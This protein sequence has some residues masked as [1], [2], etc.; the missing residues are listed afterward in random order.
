MRKTSRF[1]IPLQL[2]L[3]KGG[4][5]QQRESCKIHHM[6]FRFRS[7]VM[8][9]RVRGRKMRLRADER[10][11]ECALLK[12]FRRRTVCNMSHIFWLQLGKRPLTLSFTERS[13]L[14]STFVVLGTKQVISTSSYIE[15]GSGML[16]C[17]QLPCSCCLLSLKPGFL[18]YIERRF[19]RKPDSN[20]EKRLRPKFLQL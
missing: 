14:K 4:S 15:R 18:E 6:N 2:L 13:R 9:R 17:E 12:R 5:W 8:G 16:K 11:E 3:G 7:R 1:R 19:A 20:L 10:G